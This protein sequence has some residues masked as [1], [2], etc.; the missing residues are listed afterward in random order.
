[1]EGAATRWPSTADVWPATSALAHNLLR[2]TQT[3]GL[4]PVA[5]RARS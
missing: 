4:Q 1:V 3:I 5:Q 2:W